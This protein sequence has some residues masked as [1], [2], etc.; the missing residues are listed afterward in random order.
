MR[1][2][3]HVVLVLVCVLESLVFLKRLQTEHSQ[4]MLIFH[5]VNSTYEQTEGVFKL[6]QS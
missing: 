1:H 6:W 2:S 4:H 3:S 5:L